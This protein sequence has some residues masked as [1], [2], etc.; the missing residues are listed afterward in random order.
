M[1][2]P[3]LPA[4]ISGGSH[5]SPAG[6]PGVRW[7]VAGDIPIAAPCWGAL[8]H[9]AESP[10]IL[11]LPAATNGF[12]RWFLGHVCSKPHLDPR[13]HTELRALSGFLARSLEWNKAAIILHRVP[14]P[15]HPEPRT[16][17][18]PPAHISTTTQEPPP[19]GTQ[20][21]TSN[22]HIT[23]GTQRLFSPPALQ[24][25]E[26]TAEPVLRVSL[27]PPALLLLTSSISSSLSLFLNP[28][29]PTAH[30][31]PPGALAQLLGC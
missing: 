26:F 17:Q 13:T 30:P 11:D 28:S 5:I 15:R 2:S 8:P 22:N 3:F 16:V 31:T 12:S 24:P 20:T 6:C 18:P 27:S 10:P 4:S 23:P 25:C 19:R 29:L 21:K 7:H 14:S 1:L 9:T